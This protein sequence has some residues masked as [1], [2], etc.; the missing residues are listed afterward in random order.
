M[1]ASKPLGLQ[2]RSSYWFTTL[3]VGLGISVDLIAYSI[4][5][6]VGPFQLEKLG[7]TN[8]SELMG[9]LLFAY[10]AGLTAATIPAAFLSEHYNSRQWPLILGL[11]L[12]IGSLIMMMEAP[13]YAVM[14]VARVIQGLSS[15]LVWVV[16][17]ALLCDST[18]DTLIG[19][20]LGFALAGLSIGSL[21]GPPVAG[22]LYGKYG[23]RGP[24]IFAIIVSVVDLI[25]R[26]LVVERKDALKWEVD[27]AFVSASIVTVEDT[28]MAQVAPASS[29][30]PVRSPPENMNRQPLPFVS[31]L[32]RLSQSSRAV[33]TFLITLIYGIVYASQEPTLPLHLQSVWG[34]DSSDVGLVYLIACVPTLFSSIVTGWATDKFGPAGISILCLLF[35]LPWWVVLVLE[36]RL[37]L[38][39]TAFALQSFFTSGVVSPVCAEL[40]NVASGI[41][42]VGYAHVY[43]AFNFAYGAG[44][45]IGPVIG[46]HMYDRMARGWMALCF[47]ATGLVVFVMSIVLCYIGERPLLSRL[48]TRITKPSIPVLAPTTKA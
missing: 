3:V 19:R 12:L 24:F 39:V 9:W 23:F 32:R 1:V 47:L 48:I 13:S 38:F 41:K 30:H 42:G 10:S 16:G 6:P 34:L 25:G 40:A 7:Y 37:A 14:C 26:L 33:A 29:G 44:S 18:P 11:I 35:S 4:I 43:G 17:M 21:V 36:D 22:A 20:Q 28:E 27:P 8:V 2:W 46:G 31:V 45:T 15:S 5:V